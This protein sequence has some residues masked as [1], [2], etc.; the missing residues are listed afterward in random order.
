MLQPPTRGP[1]TSSAGWLARP[2]PLPPRRAGGRP[3]A[4]GR[5]DRSCRDQVLL[6]RRVDRR[7]GHV[8]EYVRARGPR[9]RDRVHPGHLREPITLTPVAGGAARDD[10]VPGG[11]TSAR[12]R[13]HV[14]KRQGAADA[15][16][17][18][19]RPTVAGEH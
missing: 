7:A 8:D 13:D 19:A 5:Q 2:P 11:G 4:P 6:P 12:P 15:A 18:L 1:P 16:A 14:V 3:V 10:V 9:L 17:V